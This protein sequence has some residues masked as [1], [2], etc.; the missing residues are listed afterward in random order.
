MVPP[1]LG[2]GWQTRPAN[3][4]SVV[5]SFRRASSR[6]A[7]PRRST[8]RNELLSKLVSDED[9]AAEDVIQALFYAVFMW[10]CLRRRSG[11]NPSFQTRHV[12]IVQLVGN[13]AMPVAIFWQDHARVCAA[14]SDSLYRTALW[15]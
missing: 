11:G 6:P 15:H 8:A 4:A 13:S 14:R 5:P 7:G 2:C 9:V 1:P 12:G 10:C 3:F